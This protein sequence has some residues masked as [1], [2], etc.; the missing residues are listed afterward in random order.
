MKLG[1]EQTLPGNTAAF[2][3]YLVPMVKYEGK[4]SNGE[5]KLAQQL[6]QLTREGFINHAYADDH[7]LD[8]SPSPEVIREAISISTYPVRPR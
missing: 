3:P 7:F 4:N 6:D 5:K 1:D 2:R 8:N